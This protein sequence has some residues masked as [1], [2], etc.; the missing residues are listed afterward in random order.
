MIAHGA[1]VDIVDGSGKSPL[2]AAL[3]TFNG[4]ATKGSDV[5]AEILKKALGDRTAA[6][7]Q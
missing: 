5:V 1:N 4:Q 2:D 6:V 3:A 7:V